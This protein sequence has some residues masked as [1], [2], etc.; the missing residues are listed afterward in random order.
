MK[1]ALRVTRAPVIFS[2]SS[3][4]ALCEHPRNVPDDVLKLVHDNGG[5]VMVNFFSG[6]I[7]PEGAEAARGYRAAFREMKKT[8]KD[9]KELEAAMTQWFKDHPVSR[10]GT[11]HDVVNHIEHVI[12]VAGID[13][14]G[15][16]SDFDGIPLTPDGLE[17]VSCF[18]AI[19]QLLLDRGHSPEDVKKVLGANLLRVFRAAEDVARTLQSP[20]A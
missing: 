19:T 8:S 15:L 1:H 5:V 9:D 7:V 11:I 18:P 3:A 14:V 17:D 4:F 2:H 6:F 13:H 12:K 16:G 20:P 10:R